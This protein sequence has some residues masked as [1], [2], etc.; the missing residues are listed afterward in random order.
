MKKIICFILI[1]LLVFSCIN[2]TVFAEGNV[3]S[4]IILL[5]AGGGG[6]SGGGG[7][8]GGSAGSSSHSGSRRQPTLFESIIEFSDTLYWLEIFQSVSPFFTM[9][10]PA[11][12]GVDKSVI[13]C[14]PAMI[15]S[16]F[17][18]IFAPPACLKTLRFFTLFDYTT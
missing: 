5:R 1:I 16:I 11:S 4:S 14:A 10:L 12:T 8:G 6:G 9:W 18:F 2:I 3:Q 7:S 13:I 17:L 15:L